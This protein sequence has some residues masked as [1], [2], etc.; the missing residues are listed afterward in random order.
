MQSNQ[1]TSSRAGPRGRCEEE[2]QTSCA[3]QT[4]TAQ[5]PADTHI[6][7]AVPTQTRRRSRCTRA[8]QHNNRNWRLGRDCGAPHGASSRPHKGNPKAVRGLGAKPCPSTTQQS[9]DMR[10]SLRANGKPAKAAARG[11][12][13]GLLVHVNVAEKYQVRWHY[14]RGNRLG[15]SRWRKSTRENKIWCQGSGCKA[16]TGVGT[17]TRCEG[18]IGPQESSTAQR[19]HHWPRGSL[20][21]P[22]NA[23]GVF[24]GQLFFLVKKPGLGLVVVSNRRRLPSKRRWTLSNRLRLPSNRR[25][26]HS[27]RRRLPLKCH[28]LELCRFC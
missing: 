23:R 20:I 19:N 26:L 8:H 24:R 1:S 4:C 21:G 17:G 12:F 10:T 27:N 7:T 18:F 5:P 16:C 15:Q 14:H 28:R 3:P 22:D 9:R 2:C 11:E 13:L 6:A 25:R